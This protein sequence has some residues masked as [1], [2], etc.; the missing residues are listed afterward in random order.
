MWIGGSI[1]SI[2]QLII[3]LTSAIYNALKSFNNS[4]NRQSSDIRQNSIMSFKSNDQ[5]STEDEEM[6]LKQRLSTDDYV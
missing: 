3:F 5:R 1:I 6:N 4:N 2:I